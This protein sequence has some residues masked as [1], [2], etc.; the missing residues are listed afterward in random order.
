[1]SEDEERALAEAEAEVP[2][3]VEAEDDIFDGVA[4]ELAVRESAHREGRSEERNLVLDL[5]EKDKD[6]IAVGQKPML[7]EFVKRLHKNE[8]DYRLIEVDRSVTENPE[9][10]A[11][12]R[13]ML[14]RQLS[15]ARNTER[16]KALFEGKLGFPALPPVI[17]SALVE[18]EAKLPGLPG[19]EIN[20]E[21]GQESGTSE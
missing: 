21:G 5:P 14:E 10:V 3:K 20:K 6:F 2:A 13:T 19:S 8:V 1:M 4:R 12:L 18:I 11:K 7:D 17:E 15:A 9:K 16:R